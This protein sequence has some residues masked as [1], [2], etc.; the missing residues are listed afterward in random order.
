MPTRVCPSPDLG[1]ASATLSPKGRGS[2][3]RVLTPAAR[4][5]S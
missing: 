1:F 2:Q 3:A 5:A 4:A